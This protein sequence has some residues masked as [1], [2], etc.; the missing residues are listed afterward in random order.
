M[1]TNWG[2][3]FAD[4]FSRS[5]EK[6]KEMEQ[7]AKQWVK[8]QAL[9]EAG[10]DIQRK[11]AEYANKILDMALGNPM[12]GVVQSKDLKN[13]VNEL[14]TPSSFQDVL[15]SKLS[16]PYQI[17]NNPIA[18]PK[19]PVL[20]ATPPS[21]DMTNIPKVNIGSNGKVSMSFGGDQTYT[22]GMKEDQ[23]LQAQFAKMGD[24][25][26]WNKNVRSAY[27]VTAQ[28]FHRAER[29]EGLASR[30]KDLNL[31]RR[32]MEEM[33]I[34][35]NSILQGSNQSA[36]EQV[37]GLIPKSIRGNFQKWKEWLINE[38]QGLQQQKFVSRM[39]DD[40][41]REKSVMGK[42]LLRDAVQ[43]VSKYDALRKKDPTRWS[44]IVQSWGIN[45]DDYD[46]WK[47]GGFKAIDT[48]SV[49]GENSLSNMSTE[50]LFNKLM[51]K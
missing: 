8:E 34:G 41:R 47:K 44:D 11:Q 46:A 38:P 36:Q 51:G 20:T 50:E 48:T 10:L 29:I 17:N 32:E 45:P 2:E 24:D 6:S 37:R 31:D 43:K 27:G 35:L 3:I 39:L 19:I 25:L 22:R 23:W 1:A 4:S 49:G 28:G 30:Y 16:N 7:Q 26:D 12:S 14:V 33:A 40:V 13:R 18:P 5:F 42:Q 9:K 21:I 15:A